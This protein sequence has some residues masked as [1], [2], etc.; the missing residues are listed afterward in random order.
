VCA[1]PTEAEL[2]DQGVRLG[3]EGSAL[4]LQGDLEGGP[5]ADHQGPVARE[6]LRPVGLLVLLPLQVDIFD[7]EICEE[8]KIMK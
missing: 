5:P 7:D 2:E 6:A 8:I 4:E 1:A 3:V